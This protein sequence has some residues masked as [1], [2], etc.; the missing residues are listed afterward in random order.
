ML[1]IL[2]S[3]YEDNFTNKVSQTFENFARR[4]LVI[5]YG[6][7]TR[8]AWQLAGKMKN[9]GEEMAANSRLMAGHRHT[10]GP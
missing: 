1:I 3:V 6:I 8:R 9:A 5:L 7:I 4:G 2:T 10:A